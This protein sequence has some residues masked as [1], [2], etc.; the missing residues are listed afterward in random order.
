MGGLF[1]AKTTKRLTKS[2]DKIFLGVFGGIANYFGIDETLVR[3]IGVLIFVFTGFFPLG[4]FYLLAALIMPDYNGK[5]HNDN[6]VDGEFRE[7]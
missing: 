5:K 6:F 4:V 3:V 1:M 2:K 7:K